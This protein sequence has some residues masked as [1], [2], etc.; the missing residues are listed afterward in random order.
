LKAVIVS[1]IIL[2][3]TCELHDTAKIL[4]ERV[5]MPLHSTL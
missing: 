2:N 4:A 5:A 3:S 1:A